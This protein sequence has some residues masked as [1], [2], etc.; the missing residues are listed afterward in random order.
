M[1]FDAEGNLIT[2]LY[3]LDLYIFIEYNFNMWMNR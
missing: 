1:L 2:N 3:H